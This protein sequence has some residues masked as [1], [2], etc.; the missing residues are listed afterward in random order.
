MEKHAEIKL[1]R[2]TSGISTGMEW[3]RG[4]IK[5]KIFYN[6]KIL[7]EIRLERLNLGMGG[8]EN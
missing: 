8:T 3:G 6:F 2:L 1:E 5:D 4:K 7:R